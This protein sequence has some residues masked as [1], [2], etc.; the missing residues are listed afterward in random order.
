MAAPLAPAFGIDYNEDPGRSGW[1]KRFVTERIHSPQDP[2]LVNDLSDSAASLVISRD[3]TGDKYRDAPNPML[4]KARDRQ[5]AAQELLDQFA[6]GL[7]FPQ[8]PNFPLRL[9]TGVVAYMC[10]SG[11]RVNVSANL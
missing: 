8:Q 10:G 9:C 4:A 7:A 11:K 2:T 1:T 3:L 6:D 5:S